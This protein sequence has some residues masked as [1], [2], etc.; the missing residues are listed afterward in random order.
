M[1]ATEHRL[2]GLRPLPAHD[3]GSEHRLR[4]A[5]AGPGRV[6]R[7]RG[8]RCSR[9]SGWTIRRPQADP[10]L[11]RPAAAEYAL[12]RAIANRR[13]CC[14]WTNR[15]RLDPAAPG[16]AGVLKSLQRDLGMTFIYVTHDQEEALTMSDQIAVFNEGRVEQVGS[17]AEV[18]EHP[19][20]RIRRRLRR[21]V[22][23]LERG[24]RRVCIRPERILL[25][26][27]RRR[28]AGDHRRRR[29][30]RRVHAPSV[31]LRLRRA[32]DRSSR[33]AARRFR[34]RGARRH[35][36]VT[37]T[38]PGYQGRALVM[39]R[40]ML[41]V[42]VR[43]AVGL[44]VPRRRCHQ[45]ERRHAEHDRVGGLPRPDQWVKPFEKQPGCTGAREVRRVLRR[46]GDAD[47][48]P[49]AA[50]VRHGL[51]LGR[52]LPAPDSRQGRP[53]G[54]PVE[55]SGLPHL[56]K[57]FQSPLNNTVAAKH[58]GISLRGPNTLPQHEEGNAG[59]GVV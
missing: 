16:D 58:Y 10:A 33:A 2:P 17:P 35:L 37:R 27:R 45:G 18:Y 14:S 7:P 39:T 22:E 54:R 50:A 23:H 46:D 19:G 41:F 15:S 51:G 47:G 1:R 36:V 31:P 28:R 9:R 20:E 8:A 43:V 11:G 6:E 12:A 57:T 49:A 48:V 4:T 44:P 30:R 59:T 21:H 24:G 40:S 34:A 38:H 3:R 56:N 13:R 52:R 26:R 53:G 25:L 42:V 29:V 55:D 32:V 5:R